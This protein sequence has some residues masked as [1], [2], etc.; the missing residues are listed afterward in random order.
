[1]ASRKL[2]RVKPGKK[3]SFLRSILA[4]IMGL[5]LLGLAVQ[6]VFGP[7]GQLEINRLEEEIES[8]IQEKEALESGNR[9]VMGEIE[10]LKTD[11]AAIEKI[12]REEL[13]LVREG[14]IKIV[15]KPDSHGS[16]GAAAGGDD[17]AA[18][19]G[20]LPSQQTP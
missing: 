1:M 9:Q 7:T 6:A 5:L 19:P 10:S 14:E 17:S 11:P 8:L 18:L 4:V 2:S 12:A 3:P 20:D 15:T 13:G 16:P